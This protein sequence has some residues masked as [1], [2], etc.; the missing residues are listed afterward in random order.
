MALTRS[1][2]SV[3]LCLILGLPGAA[4]SQ[5]ESQNA[6]KIQALQKQLDD[7]KAQMQNIQAQILELSSAVGRPPTTVATTPAGPPKTTVTAT[8]QD[9][10]A[11]QAAD[12]NVVP[13][14]QVSQAVAT[15]QT[16]SQDQIAAP[17]IDNAPSRS[18]LSWLLPPSRN[19]YAASHWRLLQN[20][21]HLRPEAAR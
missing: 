2:L 11:A 15:Y 19:P 12:L 20:R 9:E 8:A 4:W 10:G 16:D 17:R 5:S 7:M 3:C 6:D 21:L 1:V 18:S 14:R 13:K